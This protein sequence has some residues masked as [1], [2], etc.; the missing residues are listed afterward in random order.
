MAHLGSQRIR[1]NGDEF[2]AR[3]GTAV[4]ALRSNGFIV[5]YFVFIGFQPH[6][7]EA[8]WAATDLR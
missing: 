3:R 5:E 1:S 2:E 6:E 7:L 8:F 4:G